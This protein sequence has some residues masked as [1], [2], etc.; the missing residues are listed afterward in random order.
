MNEINKTLFIPLYGKAQVSMKN[1]ILQDKKAEEIWESEA[2]PILG[3]AKSKWLTYFMAMRA[4]VFDD[5]TDTML[6]QNKN[7]LV[8][9]IG[10][11]LDSRCFRVKEKYTKWVDADFSDVIL[12]RRRYF[13]ETEN[14]NMAVVDASK[15]DD[16]MRLPDSSEVIVILEGISM[17]LTSDELKTLIYNLQ[18]KYAAVHLLMDVYTEFAAKASKYKNPVNEVG[19]TKLYGIDD[20]EQLVAGTKIKM[21]AEHSLTPDLLINELKGFDKVFF[22][23]VFAG[24]MTGKIYKLYELETGVLR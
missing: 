11:G 24:K 8:L 5:W 3:K 17:Y 23:T 2:F 19:V 9:H 10:C 7:A 20:M 15:T 14:Y 22:K 12:Q 13:E 4:R 16:I 1:I 18:E 21:K 6:R